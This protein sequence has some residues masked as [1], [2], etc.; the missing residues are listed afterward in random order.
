MNPKT[1]ILLAAVC[2]GL[3]AGCTFPSK[4]PVVSRQQVNQVRHIQYGT[5]QKTDA[6]VVAGQNTVIGT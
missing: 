2:A 1:I 6:V 4:T 5:I 3:L